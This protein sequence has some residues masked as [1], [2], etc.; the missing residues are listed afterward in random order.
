VLSFEATVAALTASIIQ[1]RCG[2]GGPAAGERV[3]RF[4]LAQ[5]ADMPDYLRL[6]MRCL[7]LTFDAW[8]IPLA[9]RPFHRLPHERRWKTIERWR[10]S[11]LGPRRDL[12]K[13]F[14]SLA[15]FGWFADRHDPVRQDRTSAT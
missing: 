5:H 1:G 14:E 8:A 10:G 13:F 9:G 15:V 6:P 4:V 3:T 2:D 12:V 7:V 11:R